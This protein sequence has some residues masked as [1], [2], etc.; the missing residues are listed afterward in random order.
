MNAAIIAVG[1]EML[2]TQR[3]DTNSLSIAAALEKYAVVL[4][5]K[6]VIGDRQSDLVAEL[7]FGLAGF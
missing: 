5:R 6:S 1:S 4:D 3:V 2:S 7:R